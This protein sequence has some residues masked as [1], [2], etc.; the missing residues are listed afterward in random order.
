PSSSSS[1]PRRSWWRNLMPQEVGE[2]QSRQSLR[3]RSAQGMLALGIAVTL[4]TISPVARAASGSVNVFYA[5][6]LVN[7]NETLVGPAV[8]TDRPSGEHYR[9]QGPSCNLD[10]EHDTEPVPPQRNRDEA[11][12]R[13]RESH[14][15]LS[16]AGPRR[17]HANWSGQHGRLLP[18]GSEGSR[19][20]VHH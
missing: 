14:P 7:L 15:G 6:S 16:R 17:P 2:M 4:L 8:A 18:L 20:P 11:L 3:R 12:C 13:R 5:G 1:R 19:H 9:S 10:G